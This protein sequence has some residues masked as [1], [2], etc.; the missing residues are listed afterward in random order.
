MNDSTIDTKNL[1]NKAIH[2]GIESFTVGAAILKRGQLLI[3]VRSDEDSFL[4][5][6]AEI[7][8]GEV[9]NNE[10]LI[11]ALHRE[12]VEET[13]LKIKEIIRYAGS[14]DYLSGSGKKS[15]QFNFLVIPVNDEI[16]LDSSE[17]TEYVWLS[18]EDEMRIGQIKMTPEMR[19][20]IEEIR[21][22]S[23]GS[24]NNN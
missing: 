11:D 15:R 17:H 21:L 23:K 22:L 6:Y 14:F 10:S 16:I 2:E 5:G 18:M 9:E 8:G 20:C 19:R 3:I 12:T 7:P 4:A 13:G 1:L 24:D